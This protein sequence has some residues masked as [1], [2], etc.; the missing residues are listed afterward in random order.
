MAIHLEPVPIRW[1]TLEIQYTCPV[2]NK[3]Y[4]APIKSD[5]LSCEKQDVTIESEVEWD[6]DFGP[7][8][9]STLLIPLCE[10]GNAHEVKLS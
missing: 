7:T 5:V 2:S 4:M 3:Y 1:E 8:A 6:D 9:I 10:C